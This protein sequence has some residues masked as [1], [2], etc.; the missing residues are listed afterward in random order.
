MR[1]FGIHAGEDSDGSKSSGTDERQ[2]GGALRR[3]TWSPGERARARGGPLRQPPPPHPARSAT[4][5]S[6]GRLGYREA[7]S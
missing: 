5:P 3:A 1:A 6:P 7:P 4:S 2:M